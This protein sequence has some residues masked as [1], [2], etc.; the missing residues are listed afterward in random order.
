MT[1][2]ERLKN[3]IIDHANIQERFSWRGSYSLENNMKVTAEF[4]ASQ[5]S[6]DKEIE[7]FRSSNG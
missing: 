6:I 5:E 3:F 1:P 2:Q 7:L 4:R